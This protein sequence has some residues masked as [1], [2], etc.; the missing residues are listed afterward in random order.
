VLYDSTSSAGTA[1]QV[2]GAGAGGGTLT[3]RSLTN[4]SLG[5][6]PQAASASVY[7][8]QPLYY[9]TATQAI[10]Y[11]QAADD[12]TV[13]VAPT[14][15]QPVAS[16]RGRTYIVTSTGAQNLSFANTG[17]TP[18]GANDAGWY[19][20]IKN[21]NGTNGGDI[22]LTGSLMSGNTV[23]HNQT[24]TQNGQIVIVTWNGSAFIAY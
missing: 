10:S 8:N 22:T 4:T 24:S 7:L 1:N 19:L 17:A 5:A 11:I 9:N 15:L 18:L 21:G 3:W 14:S 20:Y 12:V 2:L 13:I 16:E 23:V 6:I